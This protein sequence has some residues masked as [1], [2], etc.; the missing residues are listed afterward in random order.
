MFFWVITISC[1]EGVLKTSWKKGNCYT[2]EVSRT[3]LED[4]LE[5]KCL[6]GNLW[7]WSQLEAYHRLTVSHTT[8]TIHHHHGHNLSA[9]RCSLREKCPNTELFLARIFLHS[10][11]ICAGKYGL[12]KTPYLGTFHAVVV[13][14]IIRILSV[15]TWQTS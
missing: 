3:S 7:Q 1:F 13:A 14:D 12:Q 2:E 10:D 11:W 5:T 6:L 4:V 15:D 8:K 9:E